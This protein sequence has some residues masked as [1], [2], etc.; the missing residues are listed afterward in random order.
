MAAG[1]QIAAIC[2]RLLA[3][4]RATSRVQNGGSARVDHEQAK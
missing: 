1:A 4:W 2:T 3:R